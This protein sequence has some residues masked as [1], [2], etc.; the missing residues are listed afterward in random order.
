MKH[1]A[2]WTTTATIA[3]SVIEMIICHNMAAGNWSFDK[4]LAA[5]PYKS[6]FWILFHCHIQETHF[7][8]VH[9]FMHPWRV[10]WLPD[11]GKFLYRNVHSLHH[12]SYNITAFSGTSMHPVESTIYYT[13]CMCS[14][15]FGVH[16]IIPLA[17]IFDCGL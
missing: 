14:I 3:G 15:P 7:Y 16:P 4:T 9:R 2:F 11:V 17:M 12:K 1:D 10:S 8:S 5:S 6:A 13:A